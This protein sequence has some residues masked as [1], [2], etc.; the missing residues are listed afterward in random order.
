MRKEIIFLVFIFSIQLIIN[1]DSNC[2]G[3]SIKEGTLNCSSYKT[4]LPGFSCYNI[5]RDFL[6]I[7]PEY[8]GIFP[9]YGIHADDL[10]ARHYA[11]GVVLSA[12]PCHS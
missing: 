1:D 5:R 4:K 6:F 10:A 11:L 2:L 8:C 9:R 12:V 7:Q 3:I